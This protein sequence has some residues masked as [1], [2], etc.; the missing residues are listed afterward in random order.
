MANRILIIGAGYAGVQAALTLHK[1]SKRDD[2]E[3]VLLDKNPFHTLLTELHEVAGNRI[4]EDGVIVPLQDI[5][6]YTKVS[7]VLDEIDKI[8]FIA[9]KAISKTAE[10]QYDYLILASGSRPNFYG[11]NGLEENGFTLWS[12]QDAIKIREQIK[13]C[14][15][16]ATQESNLEKRKALLTFVVGGGGFTGVETIGEIGQWVKLLCKEY[17]IPRKEVR[18]MLI[19]ALHGI[20]QNLKEKNIKKVMKYLV[21]KFL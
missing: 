8:D 18:L 5:F 2:V 19:E 11:I 20:L 10:Y 21:S 6:K 9:K 15:L 12:Y 7:V 1:K 14:F 17:S 13:H 16:L 3:I 4:S